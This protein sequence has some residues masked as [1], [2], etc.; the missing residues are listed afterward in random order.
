LSDYRVVTRLGVG[1]MAEVHLVRAPR[2]NGF[3]KLR[4]WKCLRADSNEQERAEFLPMFRD[5]AQLAM[6]LEHPNIVHAVEAGE[7]AGQP[8]ILLEFLDGQTLEHVQERARLM[9][10]G[11]SLEMT[12]WVL[13]Q[14][15]EALDYAHAL[16]DCDGTPLHIVHRDVSPQN[17]FVTYWGQGKLVDFGVAKTLKSC[18][19]RPGVV[20][21]KVPYM[22]PEQVAGG[23]IDR[24]ADL[25]S[26]GVLLWEASTGRVMYEGLGVLEALGRRGRGDIPAVRS[27]APEIDH[28]LERI[29]E[30]ALA[31]DP[32]RRYR[33]AASMRRE[34]L[35]FLDA[36]VTLHGREVGQAV[37]ALFARE[38]SE[39]REL[40][41][42]VQCQPEGRAIG[43]RP[44]RV[45]SE[46]AGVT[47]R[48]SVPESFGA[49]ATL[50][51]MAAS[52]Q[53]ARSR[54]RAGA[55]AGL[56]L[57]LFGT[58]ALLAA[59]GFGPAARHDFAAART[60][61]RPN[62]PPAEAPP[63]GDIGTMD[64]DI[65][66]TIQLEPSRWAAKATAEREGE[67]WASTAG[68]PATSSRDA[69][70]TP[71]IKIRARTPPTL[72]PLPEGRAPLRSP[73][74]SQP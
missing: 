42:R 22:A 69:K 59:G 47:R 36:R 5:E 32:Q 2:C 30:R 18:K 24:R 19:S 29:I 39:L 46:V 57:V 61:P 74:N 9:G 45:S 33:D 34:L 72:P 6:R 3:G 53:A 31:I 17:V 35:E 62:P 71:P 70:R 11:F 1:G 25:F 66:S 13:C 16:T 7:V 12:V 68:G 55:W 27:L 60:G 10:G 15:L 40:I 67:A 43:G 56:S 64:T 52:V 14:V 58:V 26:V 4:V 8:F 50:P 23:P 49:G 51:P 21:G 63:D 20:K 41:A 44:S 65:D 48:L 54:V 28:A 73:A 37:A 38:R